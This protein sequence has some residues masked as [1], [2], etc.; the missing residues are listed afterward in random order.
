MDEVRVPARRRQSCGDASCASAARSLS[1]S[2]TSS[3]RP[4]VLSAN[5]LTLIR[6]CRRP[7]TI[8]P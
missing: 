4:W 7:P 8:W 2:H 5:G 1:R 6:T 3:S